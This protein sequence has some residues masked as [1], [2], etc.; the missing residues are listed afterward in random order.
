MSL[1][2]GNRNDIAQL[3]PLLDKV[4]A[5]AGLVDRH[6]RRPDMLFADR[7]YNHEAFLGLATCLI[8]HRPVQRLCED[9]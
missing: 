1:T 8:T 7:D 2:G 3:L 9:L 5:V 4:P 6:R